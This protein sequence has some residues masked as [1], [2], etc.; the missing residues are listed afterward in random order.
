M[1]DVRKEFVRMAAGRELRRILMLIQGED[2][3]AVYE[4]LILQ[5]LD[6]PTAE[7]LA[8]HDLGA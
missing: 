1:D 4:D 5:G 6:L 7:E 8:D 2:W 3:E